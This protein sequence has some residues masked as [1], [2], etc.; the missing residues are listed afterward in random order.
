MSVL[1]PVCCST[2]TLACPSTM[3]RFYAAK[4]GNRIFHAGGPAGLRLPWSSDPELWERWASGRTGMP[5]V[6]ANMRE[7]QQTG[8][9]SNRGRQNVASYLALDLGVDWRRGADLFEHLL[10]DYD[11]ASNW[12]NWVAAA[13]LTGGRVNHFNITKVR[14]WQQRQ[15]CCQGRGALNLLDDIRAVSL[16]CSSSYASVGFLT[17]LSLFPSCTRHVSDLVPAPAAAA[18]PAAK[19]GL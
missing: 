16:L 10:L 19:Q 15:H 5:L 17:F 4:Q 14:Q 18:A 13:G 9:M 11:P 12:G 7:L 6:D 3:R 1:L 2:A 8:W